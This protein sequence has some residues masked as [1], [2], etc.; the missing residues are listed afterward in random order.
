MSV[1]FRPATLK[2]TWNPP[3]V[4]E[5]YLYIQSVKGWAQV[6]MNH[7]LISNFVL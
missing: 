7:C 6:T 4:C 3:T 1:S 5:I 2:H